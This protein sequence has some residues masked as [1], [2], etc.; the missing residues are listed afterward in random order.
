MRIWLIK[1][2]LLFTPFT[3]FSKLASR[4]GKKASWSMKCRQNASWACSQRVHPHTKRSLLTCLKRGLPAPLN[5]F[6]WYWESRICK[7]FSWGRLCAFWRYA[8]AENALVAVGYSSRATI[9]WWLTAPI[10]RCVVL[11][12]A[13]AWPRCWHRCRATIPFW[14]LWIRLPRCRRGAH[15]YAAWQCRAFYKHK[16][17]GEKTAGSAHLIQKEKGSLSEGTRVRF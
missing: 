4:Q 13:G 17:F 2:I 3:G 8:F 1:Y 14:W 5:R 6:S 9:D 16:A 10:S 11:D 7:S 15:H 12:D